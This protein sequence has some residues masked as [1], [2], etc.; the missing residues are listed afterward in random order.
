M[1]SGR[2]PACDAVLPLAGSNNASGDKY[3][4]TGRDNTNYYPSMQPVLS[5]NRCDHDKNSLKVS[6]VYGARKST[7]RRPQVIEET[8]RCLQYLASRI[9]D[10]ICRDDVEREKNKPTGV[11]QWFVS[12][13]ENPGF[14]RFLYHIGDGKPG[15]KVRSEG[16]EST[17]LI[18]LGTLIFGLDLHKMAYGYYDKANRFV[19]FD[20]GSLIKNSGLS[21]SRL[22]RAMKFLKEIGIISVSPIVKTLNDGKKITVETRITVSEEI[23]M[24][25]GIHK[26][27]LQ[28]RQY[29]SINYEKRQKP[30]DARQK[31]LDLYKAPL[32]S[33]KSFKQRQTLQA[34]IQ[35]IAKSP[36]KPAQKG[37]GQEIKDLYGNLT[38]QG[39][40][41][42]EAAEII[43]TK[44]PPPH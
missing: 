21:L 18:T 5:G 16:F 8:G 36:Y 25:L 41:P 24:I 34:G 44:Y 15:R 26:E 6:P 28:D 22:N 42:A 14:L 11:L 31:Y 32:K 3:S 7:N 1:D 37:R 35:S 40:T 38:A 33:K 23:F 39:L 2:M 43:R 12:L 17:L 19:F 27:F 20:Y 13:F 4:S 30:I 29:A 9:R 10:G